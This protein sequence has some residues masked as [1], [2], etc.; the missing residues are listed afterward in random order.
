MFLESLVICFDGWN[1]KTMAFVLRLFFPSN[2]CSIW[3]NLSTFLP[4][5]YPIQMTQKH[6][7]KNKLNP[8]RVLGNKT[9][10]LQ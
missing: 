6:T 7:T 8:N 5:Q 3:R 9:E 10:D 2:K 1:M 4:Y